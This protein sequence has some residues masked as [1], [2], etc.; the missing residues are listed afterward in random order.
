MFGYVMGQRQ[1]LP[2]LSIAKCIESYLNYFNVDGDVGLL[3]IEYNRMDQELR[4]S[5]KS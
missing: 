5:E 3:R 1:A 2:S 4:E